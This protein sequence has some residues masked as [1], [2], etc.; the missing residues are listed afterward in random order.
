MALLFQFSPRLSHQARYAILLAALGFSVLGPSALAGLERVRVKSPQSAIETDFE[1]ATALRKGGWRPAVPVQEAG[2]VSSKRPERPAFD[3]NLSTFVGGLF[4]CARNLERASVFVVAAWLLG[5]CVAGGILGFGA[6]AVERL[7]REA[8]PASEETSARAD[9]LARRL[10]LRKSPLVLVHRRIAEPCLLGVF[11]PAILIPKR[12]LAAAKTDILDAMLAHELAH[13]RR[14][15][16]WVNLAQRLIESVLFFHPA[17]RWLSRSLRSQREICTDRLAVRVTQNPLAM[18]QALE[19]V[20]R[21]RLRTGSPILAG[22]SLGGEST[23]LLSRIQELFGMKPTRRRTQIWPFAAIPLAGF[24]ALVAISDGRAQNRAGEFST[25]TTAEKRQF[26]GQVTDRQICYEI[27]FLSFDAENWRD[28]LKDR[29]KAVKDDAGSSAWVINATAFA[30]LLKL[31]QTASS[32]DEVRDLNATAFENTTARIFDT[33]KQ[34]YVAQLERVENPSAPVFRPIVKKMDIGLRLDLSGTLEGRGTRLSVDLRD[35]KLL[36][37]HTL[38]RRERIGEEIV[39]AEY[40]VPSLVEQR[41]QLGCAIPEGSAVVISL[42]LQEYRSVAAGAAHAAS[43]L[44][45]LVGLPAMPARS[46]ACERLVVIRPR[47]ISL[48]ELDRPGA[49]AR[50]EPQEGKNR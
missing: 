4:Y 28:L 47:E 16:Q 48:E 3:R 33:T 39:A 13:A 40:Q 50:K 10:G 44:L 42:G 14:G 19:S 25:G 11:R 23:S 1:V 38:L 7:R 41:C 26:A 29:L 17:V 34:S 36:A 9:A 18:A 46:A 8:E 5:V 27:R 32:A 35:T 37:M 12:W 6:M 15:D 31:G 45:K 24:F 43:G 22:T 30:D 21:A 20:A 2:A 49:T